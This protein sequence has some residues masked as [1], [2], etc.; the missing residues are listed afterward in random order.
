VSVLIEAIISLKIPE[1]WMNEI[2]KAHPATIKV[3]DCMP[4]GRAG[5][6]GLV[7]INALDDEL[8]EIVEEIRMLPTICK[9]DIASSEKGKIIGAVATNKCVA[10]KAL[11]G[12]DCFLTSASSKMDGKIEWTLITGGKASLQ[13]LFKK[14]E[15]FHCQAEIVR[16]SNINDK[17]IL[18]A[19]QKEIVRIALEKGYFDYP[20]KTN[21]RELANDFD[22]SISTLSE[23]LRKGQ[24]KIILKYFR[25]YTH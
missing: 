6:R 10:C 3:I 12:S 25:E 19:R 23:I 8:S 14:L 24:R 2:V 11:T 1:N 16:V 20:K 13:H 18:T 7:E 15:E 21:I 4:F 22:I 5:G 9:I 17:N